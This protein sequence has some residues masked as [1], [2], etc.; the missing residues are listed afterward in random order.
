MAVPARPF[1]AFIHL[2]SAM[3]C[4]TQI[5]ERAPIILTVC[6]IGNGYFAIKDIFDD[7][8]A[9]DAHDKRFFDRLAKRQP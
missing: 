8:W 9:E 7:A 4:A 6:M 1:C 2:W 3:L 5:D